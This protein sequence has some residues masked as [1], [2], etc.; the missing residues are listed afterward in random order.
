M[1]QEKDELVLHIR[2]D[3]K[4]LLEFKEDGV[5]RTKVVS[6]DTMTN[7]FKDSIK[8]ISISTG[9]LPEK[10]LSFRSVIEGGKKY[11]TLEFPEDK[12]RIVYEGTEYPDFPI[13]R[14]VFGFSIDKNG[15]ILSVNLGVPALGRFNPDT[16]MYKYPFSNVNGFGLCT[17]GNELPKITSLHQL[18]GV[19]Y[20]I[21]SMP[22][23]DDFYRTE[24]NLLNLGHR[25][26]LEHLK[27][28][29]RQYYYDNILVPM[30]N[31]ALKDFL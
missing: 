2:E 16:P 8:G 3:Q 25:D 28:K 12:A 4:I 13:P 11:I 10:A 5:V 22:D 7:C 15:R 18:V 1:L 23:N 9:L 14:I 20:Y 30:D 31:K 27:D 17:G 29:D 24:N 6:V 19:M 26:L 21:I